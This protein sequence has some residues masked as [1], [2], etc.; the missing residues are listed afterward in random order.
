MFLNKIISFKE[1]EYLWNIYPTTDL[2]GKSTVEKMIGNLANSF[3]VDDTKKVINKILAYKENE[4]TV[5]NLSLLRSLK[6]HPLLSEDFIF[7]ILE[8]MWKIITQKSTSVTE[9]IE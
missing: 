4:F 9:T 5:D 7:N 1:I 6:E 3:T 8:S 2:R